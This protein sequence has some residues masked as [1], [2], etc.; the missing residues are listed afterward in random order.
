M[1]VS[2]FLLF[3]RHFPQFKPFPSPFGTFYLL[4]CPLNTPAKR[5]FE[6]DYQPQGHK[7]KRCCQRHK[8]GNRIQ[9]LEAHA[10]QLSHKPLWSPNLRLTML[11][12][13]F[14][15]P[16]R[17]LSPVGKSGQCRG[18]GASRGNREGATSSKYGPIPRQLL[19]PDA[20][21]HRDSTMRDIF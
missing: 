21:V 5:Y 10:W 20:S 13:S 2:A 1:T 16:H 4:V 6:K 11:D 19:A 14:S 17:C 9:P 7:D 12:K 8:K 15:F 3:L 18:F